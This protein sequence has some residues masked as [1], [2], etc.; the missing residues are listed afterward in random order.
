MSTSTIHTAQPVARPVITARHSFDLLGGI[1]PQPIAHGFN[2]NIK[3]A[4][5]TDDSI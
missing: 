1:R 2:R 4:G 3:R 5:G